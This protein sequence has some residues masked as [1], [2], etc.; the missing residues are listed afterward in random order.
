MSTG[1]GHNSILYTRAVA[2]S[3]V[4]GRRKVTGFS[5][6][7]PVAQG[8]KKLAS[9]K[10]LPPSLRWTFALADSR[11]RGTVFLGLEDVALSMA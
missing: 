8:E 4:G 9:G 2:S 10:K 3:L 11:S 6:K 5:Q 7:T 1:C